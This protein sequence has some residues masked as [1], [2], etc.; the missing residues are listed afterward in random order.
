MK[1]PTFLEGV[2]VALG[3]S[4]FG[5]VMYTALVPLFAGGTV[6]RLLLAVIGLGYVVYLMRRSHERVGRITM[7][8]VWGL[9]TLATWLLQP[10][11]LLFVVVQ[12]GMIWLV[13]ALYFHGSVLSALADLGLTGMSLSAA[14]WASIHTGS[15]F[16]SI[17]CFF[18]VQTLFVAIP[19][20]ISRRSAIGPDT[21]EG[22][23][24]FQQ[25]YRE[26]ESALRKFSS[27]H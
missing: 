21:A 5:S 6:L 2:A 14:V 13:R 24:R 25:A 9:V 18:L 7:L 10:S 26:A 22:G 4:V 12:L 11:L 1:P 19:H 23:D 3:A 20:D 15:L 8:L 16:L 17:W 27:T